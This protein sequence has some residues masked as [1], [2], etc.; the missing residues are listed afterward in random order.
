LKDNRSFARLFPGPTRIQVGFG[1]RL[2]QRTPA[3]AGKLSDNKPFKTDRRGVR[4]PECVPLRHAKVSRAGSEP[5]SMS[6]IEVNFMFVYHGRFAVRALRMQRFPPH[7]HRPGALLSAALSRCPLA[8]HALCAAVHSNSTALSSRVIN[9]DLSGRGRTA[10]VFAPSRF[11]PTLSRPFPRFSPVQ[12]TALAFE[13]QL[14]QRR[15]E[16]VI[17]I[18]AVEDV[19]TIS[20]TRH[21]SD[22]DQDCKLPLHSPQCQLAPTRD[23][24]HI[25][26]ASRVMKERAQHLGSHHWKKQI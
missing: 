16:H 24:A 18:G 8:G 25:H 17:A 3:V 6:E 22:L 23:F 11:S 20:S 21:Q 13:N 2:L 5:Y 26:L 14:M 7:F 15:K 9:V 12:H 19:V 4:S 1:E 10:L